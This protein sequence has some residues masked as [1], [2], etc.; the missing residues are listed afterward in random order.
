MVSAIVGLKQDNRMESDWRTC[1][2]GDSGKL[3]KGGNNQTANHKKDPALG[4]HHDD[5]LGK[6]IPD[7][8]SH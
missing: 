2:D 5:W 6:T 3:S 7:K 1:Q 8:G 4:I